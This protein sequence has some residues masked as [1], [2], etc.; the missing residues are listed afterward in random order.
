MKTTT[1][2]GRLSIAALGC[3]LGMLSDRSA[4]QEDDYE[5]VPLHAWSLGETGG[6]DATAMLAEGFPGL[7]AEP[8]KDRWIECVDGSGGFDNVAPRLGAEEGPGGLEFDPSP[9]YRTRFR[10]GTNYLANGTNRPGNNW[11]LKLPYA[12]HNPYSNYWTVRFDANTF[13]R[14]DWN[15]YALTYDGRYGNSRSRL[16]VTGVPP[17]RTLVVYDIAGKAWT[18]LETDGFKCSKIDGVG[19]A[20]ITIT[21]AAGSITLYQKPSAT[22]GSEVR[23]FLFTIT[24]HGSGDRIDKVDVAEKQG[25]PTSG[26]TSSNTSPGLLTRRATP[27][28]PTRWRP[29][30]SRGP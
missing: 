23:R 6:E 7:S 21:Y 12:V 2:L 11:F 13:R 30:S 28:T 15:P 25:R 22:G 16:V 20:E 18:F 5:F 8:G 29:C 9:T 17:F 27:A 4:A 1:T 19:D 26:T 10:N 24:N 14:Y 3:I